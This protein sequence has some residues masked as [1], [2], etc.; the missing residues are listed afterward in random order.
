MGLRGPGAKPIAKA[1]PNSAEGATL[2]NF[3]SHDPRPQAPAWEAPGLSRAG[4]VIAFVES[5]QIT[6]GRHAGKPFVLRDWQKEIIGEIYAEDEEGARPV[7]TAVLSLGRKNG[8]TAIAAAL[9]LCHLAGP[10][11]EQRGE[12]YSAA[13]DRFQAAKIFNEMVAMIER[14]PLL[15][16][17]INV[18]RFTKQ[19]EDFRTG[20]IYAALSADAKTKLGLSPSFV[21]YDELGQSESRD[22]YDA[23]D[24]AMGARESPLLMV[25]STQAPSD[26]APLSGLVD[27]GL[28]VQSGAIDDPSFKLFFYTAP[29]END[30]WA[31]ESW[32]LANPALGDFLS[33]DEVRRQAEQARRMP[34]KEPAFRNLILNQ[35]VSGERHFL[36]ASE[37]MACPPP[38]APEALR[39]RPCFAG[40]DL[41][42]VRDLTALVLAFPDD[43][44]GFDVLPFLWLPGDNLRA[45]EDEDKVPYLAWKMSGHL[46][47]TP[48]ATID[49]AFIAAKVA[50]LAAVYDLR[51]IG[52]DRWRI[53]D[54]KRA[55]AETGAEIPLEAY[56]QGF[57]DMAPAVDLV[58]RLIVERRLRH[59]GH[60]I[61]TWNATNAVATADPAGNRKLDKSRSRG[62]IDGLV[63]MAMALAVAARHG[64]EPD[65][66]PMF[67]VI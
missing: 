40:L 51:M 5:L 59:G 29:P 24:T 45:R 34:A 9:A 8:K 67:E 63:A 20:S 47:T 57:K 64:K 19:L 21:I 50:E 23:L 25:I 2:F 32:R 18:T 53:D 61:L 35:R 13:N 16:A 62:R 44:G 4:R 28:K 66:S 42:S 6:A 65:W 12:V 54:F 10:E 43:A 11:A 48:G 3:R 31:E 7:R 58:E 27:Y 15:V 22:L 14:H 52:F 38:A 46:L 39:G 49:P 41:S 30:P 37:W 1:E 36:T 26:V 60:P 33:L 56:G 55:L 17:R